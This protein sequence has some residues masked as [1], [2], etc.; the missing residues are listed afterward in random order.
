MQKLLSGLK[1]TFLSKKFIGYCLIGI[2]NTFNTAFFSWLVHFKVQENISA[3]IGYFISLTINYILNSVI[4]FKNRLR[5]RRY[6]RFLLSYIPNFVIY[7]LVSLLTINVMQINQFWATV[8]AT[9]AG[10]P[11]TFIILKLFAFGSKSKTE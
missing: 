4:V 7:T 5:I 8:L 2:L 10:A 6:F 1:N 9:A 3:Y 11:I